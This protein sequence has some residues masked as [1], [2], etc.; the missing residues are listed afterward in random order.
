V[1]VNLAA[2]NYVSIATT[3][4][5]D[6]VEHYIAS[7][8]LGK[9]TYALEGLQRFEVSQLTLFYS[10]VICW[11]AGNDT[12]AIRLLE[13]CQENEHAN[14]LLRHITKPKIEVLSQLD[15]G[16]WSCIFN[17]IKHDRKF[18]LTNIGFKDGDLLNHVSASIHEYYNPQ[19]PPDFYITKML[20][21][22]LIPSDI[23]DLPCPILAQSADYDIHIQIVSPWLNVFDELIIEHEW[24]DVA[25]LTQAPVVTYPKAYPLLADALHTPLVNGDRDIDIFISGTTFHPYHPDKALLLNS[26][27]ELE[28][29]N[30][31]FID[32]FLGTSVYLPLLLRTKICITYV[33]RPGMPT[34]GLEALAM[35]CAVLVQENS[36]LLMYLKDS[37]GVFSYNEE[38]LTQK[39]HYILANWDVLKPGIDR[40]AAFVRSE[41]ETTKM[42]S[43]YF[44]FLTY[45]AAKPRQ[46]RKMVSRELL[47]HKRLIL[48]KGW[49]LQPEIYRSLASKVLKDLEHAQTAGMA[50]ASHFV[51]AAREMVLEYASSAHP[52]Y[53]EDFERIFGVRGVTDQTLLD[54]ALQ[55][56]KDGI[57]LFPR[58]LIL[59]LNYIRTALLFGEQEEIRK[60]LVMGEETVRQSL[61]TWEVEPLHDVFPWDYFS[62]LFNYREYFDQVVAGLRGGCHNYLGLIRLA[63]ASIHYHLSFYVD[64]KEH[65][66]KAYELDGTFPF[67]QLHYARLLSRSQDEEERRTAAE[68]FCQLARTS[69]LARKACEEL[70]ELAA[71]D[72]YAAGLSASLQKKR[73]VLE[74]RIIKAEGGSFDYAVVPLKGLTASEPPVCLSGSTAGDSACPVK[75]YDI[76]FIC[77]EFSRW[78]QARSWSYQT[79]L[80]LEEGFSANGMSFVTVPV[81]Q[82]LSPGDPGSWLSY[83]EEICRDKQ[84]DQVWIEVVHNVLD[85]QTLAFLENVAPIRIALIAESLSYPEE[86]YSHAAH[87]Q[88]RRALVL[89]RLKYMTHALLG[90]EADAQWL[91][92]AGV[93]KALWWVQGMPSWTLDLPHAKPTSGKASF[94]GAVYGDRQYWLE[95]PQ[96]KDVVRQERS[97]E[98]ELGLP[99]LYDQL[100]QE[101]IAML[102]EKGGFSQ[103]LLDRHLDSL[104]L[105]RKCCFELWLKGLTR[106]TA[107]VNLPSF[108]QAYPGR[109]YEG[110]AA[111]RPV[112]SWEIPGRPRTKALFEDGKEILLFPNDAP[113]KLAEQIRKISHDPDFAK[114]IVD[115]ALLKLSRYHTMEM[116]VRQILAWIESGAEPDYGEMNRSTSDRN[117]IDSFYVDLWHDPSW[118]SPY[119]NADENMRWYKMST[120]LEKYCQERIKHKLGAPKVLDVGCGRGW[121]SRYLAPYGEYL[122]IEPVAG[123]VDIARQLFPGAVF[124]CSITEDLLPQ[125]KNA[126]QVIVSTEVV[127]HIPYDRQT[128]FIE[129]LYALLADD[130]LLIMTTPRKEIYDYILTRGLCPQP[131]EDWLSEDEFE[132]LVTSQGFNVYGMERVYYD[133]G[134]GGF[135]QNPPQQEIDAHGLIALYQVWGLVKGSYASAST[136]S[137]EEKTADPMVS[138]IVPTYNRP[139]M[140]VTTIRSILNQTFQDFEVIIVNDAGQDVRSVIQSFNSPRLVYLS[141]AT[142]KG[143][144]AARNTGIRAARGKYI[145]YLDDDDIYYPQHLEVLVSF[146]EKNDCKVAYTDAYRATQQLLDGRYQTVARECLYSFDFDYDRILWQNFVPVLCFMHEKVCLEQAGMFDETLFRH[147]DWDLWIRMSRIYQFA[148]LPR[149]TCEYTYRLDGTGMVSGSVPSF[150]RSFDRISQKYSYLT[151]SRPEIRDAIANSRFMM[152]YGTFDFLGRKLATLQE[153]NL[154]AASTA[155][156]FD[157]LKSTGATMEELTSAVFQEAGRAAFHNYT[158]ARELLSRSIEICPE[159]VLARQ[160]LAEL[161]MSSGDVDAAIG[162]L[163]MLFEINPIEPQLLCTLA[164]HYWAKARKRALFFY[165]ILLRV[166][167]SHYEARTRTAEGITQ[168]GA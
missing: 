1:S 5:V 120:I 168:V 91:N 30:T 93:V 144:A 26:I 133:A 89:H 147:E 115:N 138:V 48:L 95:H 79:G 42:A 148:H 94:S 149:V 34:R 152:L 163:E 124:Q 154:L 158:V 27:L 88:Q 83:L 39:I 102:Q 117:D 22:H 24:D 108:Y 161:L 56:Y 61:S 126:F 72:S 38:N 105:I 97:P 49:L 73:A 10:G 159:N 141:H 139:Y 145:A 98:Y 40:A 69:M 114:K 71:D 7:G 16:S 46:P 122:G 23:Q 76:L 31:V 63:I 146:L 6:R 130:G 4:N 134:T 110:M 80:G 109:I 67:Y 17:A 165:E 90:D 14:N 21:W 167:P 65:A 155:E 103:E 35:G 33:R 74:K 57:K 84:F 18:S 78:Q 13:Q 123:A 70:Q 92:D 164:R 156:L 41:F 121:L 135:Y 150:L 136:M 116:R 129:D 25:P 143:L 118:S 166:D 29:L 137:F 8:L 132:C 62:Q 113:L 87:L 28:G 19:H 128:S 2:G 32:G 36:S 86:V 131:V 140:L 112:V 53:A 20:E 160:K 66:A 82:D 106:G 50:L 151:T 81:I 47:V 85:E 68:L 52:D 9:T 77:L 127:E 75:H 45:L 58:A 15:R 12:E 60:A 59:R 111:G 54:R 64:E 104:R 51:D 3:H 101:I 37:E 11:I 44:R 55:C 153:Q 43:Q 162:H 96:L 100:N 119:P 125:Y 142:N 107:V 157:Q 99:D